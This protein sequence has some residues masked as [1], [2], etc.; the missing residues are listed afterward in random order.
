MPA[1][2]ERGFVFE[3]DLISS[4]LATE[5]TGVRPGAEDTFSTQSLQARW[6]LHC[7]TCPRCTRRDT[8]LEAC[9]REDFQWKRAQLF[10]SLSVLSAKPADVA[11]PV[12]G[13]QDRRKTG[14]S[15]RFTRQL[16]QEMVHLRRQLL[17]PGATL[18][19]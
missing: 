8:P 16:L 2:C 18:Q 19:P 4:T 15:T 13:R 11:P 1:R 12:P 9:L 10:S 5:L 17:K 3:E 7:K 6:V 14:L